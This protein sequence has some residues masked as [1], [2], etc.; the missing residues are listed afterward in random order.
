[1]YLSVFSPN[2]EKYGPEHSVFGHFSRSVA[3]NTFYIS[4]DFAVNTIA[5][6]I[7]SFYEVWPW[8]KLKR[9]VFSVIILEG[10]LSFFI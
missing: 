3:I 9:F 6:I 7:V 10:E 8:N 1:M 2:A 5:E 4:K